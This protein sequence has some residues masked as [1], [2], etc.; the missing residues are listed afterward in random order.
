[1]SSE[2]TIDYTLSYKISV[3]IDKAR[4]ELDYLWGECDGDEEQFLEFVEDVVMASLE[5]FEELKLRGEGL[6]YWVTHFSL[7]EHLD[8]G[9]NDD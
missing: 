5:H 9:V 2:L 8:N 6:P 3:D 1:M 7:E 4:E